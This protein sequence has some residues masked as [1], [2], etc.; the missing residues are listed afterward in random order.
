MKFAISGSNQ[1]H[2]MAEVSFA[3]SVVNLCTSGSCLEMKMCKYLTLKLLPA[4]PD[5]GISETPVQCR[6]CAAPG[7]GTEQLLHRQWFEADGGRQG[8]KQ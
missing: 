2:L 4:E 3:A 5:P 1:A 7:K 8:S 6:S